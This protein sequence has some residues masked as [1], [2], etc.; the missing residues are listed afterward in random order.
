VKI[1]S[2]LFV[3]AFGVIAPLLI[4][5]VAG[6]IVLSRYERE[7][8]VREAIGRT[9]AAMS[10]I[11]TELGG[12]IAALKALAASKISKTATFGHSTRKRTGCLRRSP[13]GAISA[14][15]PS[16]ASS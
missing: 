1:Q 2:H 16:S 5:L 15:R 4:V 14:W 13:S 6:G 7:A 8:F 12:S 3:L 10:A 9:R 11:D